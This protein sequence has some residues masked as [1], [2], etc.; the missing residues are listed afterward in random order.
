M[1]GNSAD[2]QADTTAAAS[3]GAQLAPE[4]VPMLE[5][6]KVP[7]NSRGITR[8]AEELLTDNLGRGMAYRARAVDR[9]GMHEFHD[10]CHSVVSGKLQIP[11]RALPHGGAPD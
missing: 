9:G 7:S 11:P 3:S 1:L 5:N 10:A 2:R 6:G 4:F 8:A